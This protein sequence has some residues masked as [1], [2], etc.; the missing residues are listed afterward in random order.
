MK[1][2]LLLT[3]IGLTACQ[4]ATEIGTTHQ[5]SAKQLATQSDMSAITGKTL[6]FGAGQSFIISDNG[7]L[8]GF[9]DG[10]PLVGNYEMKDGFFCRTA[11]SRA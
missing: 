9:W 1:Y 7:T 8:A 3:L 6:T 2:L 11:F 4:T 10:N 5:V